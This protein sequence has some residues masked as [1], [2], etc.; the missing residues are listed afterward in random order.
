MSANRQTNRPACDL[1]GRIAV[2]RQPGDRHDV[3][4]A[5]Y[6]N[7]HVV[8]FAVTGLLASAIGS[9]VI[10]RD[11]NGMKAAW[12][13]GIRDAIPRIAPWPDWQILRDTILESIATS[14][15]SFLASAD[16]L[17]AEPPEYWKDCLESSTWVVMEQGN[18]VLG[19]AAAKPPSMVDAYAPQEKACFIES[20]WIDPTMRGNGFGERLVTYL[21]EQRRATG[22]QYFYLWVFDHNTPAIHLYESM[23]FK[24]TGQPSELLCPLEI[25]YLLKF[26]SDVLD[27]D[28]LKRNE[29]A[30]LWDQADYGITYR[31]LTANAP[32]PYLPLPDR[33]LGRQ[34]AGSMSRHLKAAIWDRKSSRLVK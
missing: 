19:I 26:D 16:Q 29:A 21:M 23:A 3:Q 6:R 4:K 7:Q 11:G 22:I 8:E 32:W 17:N 34:A 20:V 31:R 30:R 5:R 1:R 18:K 25:Q 13:G 27:D 15:D 2:F 9:H 14:P 10:R 24:P 12:V 28:E 33:L